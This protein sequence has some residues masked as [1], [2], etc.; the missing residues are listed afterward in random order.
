MSASIANPQLFNHQP[1][2]GAISGHWSLTDNPHLLRALEHSFA[3]NDKP[4]DPE[5]AWEQDFDLVFCG[6]QNFPQLH[7]V[8]QG[9]VHLWRKQG[10][11]ETVSLK[12]QQGHIL[13]PHE[14]REWQL[15]EQEAIH[16][17]D[18]LCTI[19]DDAAWTVRSRT[20][21][22]ADPYARPFS[23]SCE[24]A[25]LKSEGNS[26]FWERRIDSLKKARHSIP[27]SLPVTTSLGLIEACHRLA[28]SESSTLS[29]GIFKDGTSW[30]ADQRLKALM[31]T[32][33]TV[34]GDTFNLHGFVQTGPGH[35]P[36]FYWF[37]EHH[38]LA[39]IRKGVLCLLANPKPVMKDRCP[40][41][42]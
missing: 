19:P 9:W 22:Q 20:L 41:E 2:P 21:G 14:N 18:T 42:A 35:L 13:G 8:Y 17:Q 28:P 23:E 24:W 12:L 37:D 26:R 36:T 1:T 27:A 32:V 6:P 4:H 5:G 29:F 10:P 31:P 34:N 11:D 40:H 16:H 39:A 25:V 33:L 3:L 7:W 30:F 15:I 38:R